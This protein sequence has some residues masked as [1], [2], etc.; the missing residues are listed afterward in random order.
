MKNLLFLIVSL[1]TASLSFAQV[2]P[3]AFIDMLPSIPDNVCSKEIAERNMFISQADS[4]SELIDN[5]RSRRDE[6][7][8]ADSDEYEKQAMDKLSKQYGLSQEELE[9]LQN[10]DG[11]TEEETDEL[12]NK[13]L[14]NSE[15]ISLDE[16]KDSE[17]MSEEGKEAWSE[18]YSTEKMSETQADPQKYQEQQLQYKNRFELAALQKHIL[19]S[20]TAIESKFAQQIAELDKDPNAKIMLDNIYKWELEATE[21]MGELSESEAAKLEELAQQIQSEKDKYCN[22]YTPAYLDILRRYESYTKSCL[23]VC[24]RLEKI[25]A[26]LTKLQTGVDMKQESGLMGIKKVSDYLGLLRGAFKYN[27]NK[28]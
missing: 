21:M 13:A 12:I 15:N 9:K 10:E 27:L 19:D 17:K 2:T 3:E 1:V 23:P 25:S 24:Y 14:Q 22:K 5:E 8:D 7:I 20:L 26:Q 28:D 6:N 16:I 11:M 18:A 4:V